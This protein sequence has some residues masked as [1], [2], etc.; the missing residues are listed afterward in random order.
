[1]FCV[2]YDLGY[3]GTMCE[4]AEGVSFMVNRFHR[5]VMDFIQSM[6]PLGTPLE[7]GEVMN[8]YILVEVNPNILGRDV[9]GIYILFQIAS[10][11]AF[12][13]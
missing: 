1:M 8:P 7:N 5:E 6:G 11:V 9:E 2:Y 3:S 10:F 13:A 12:L 4:K